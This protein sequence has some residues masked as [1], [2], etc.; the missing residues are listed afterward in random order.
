MDPKTLFLL[1]GVL[2]VLYILTRLTAPFRQQADTS[3]SHD[4]GRILQEHI[5]DDEFDVLAGQEADEVLNLFFDPSRR[6]EGRA[7]WGLPD[8][9]KE[10]CV[11]CQIAHEPP[12]CN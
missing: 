1:L 7:A 4:F 9:G 5:V 8:D 2:V 11:R 10:W 6:R 3:E 12:I